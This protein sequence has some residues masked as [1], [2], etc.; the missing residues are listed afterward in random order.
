[1]TPFSKSWSLHQTQYGSVRD[2]SDGQVRVTTRSR[3][4]TMPEYM[5]PSA[6]WQATAQASSRPVCMVIARQ[7]QPQGAFAFGQVGGDDM[8][9]R[10]TVPGETPTLPPC[11]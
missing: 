11:Q 4:P 2:E 6:C 10:F 5:D 1:M 8:T 7:R 3:C 9:G